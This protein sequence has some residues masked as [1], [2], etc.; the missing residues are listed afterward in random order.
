VSC[1][2]NGNEIDWVSACPSSFG[3]IV[4][5]SASIPSNGW[6]GWGRSSH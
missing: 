6:C 5:F 1:Y 4:G 3:E 2:G